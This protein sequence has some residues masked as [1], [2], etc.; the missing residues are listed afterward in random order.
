MDARHTALMSDAAKVRVVPFEGDDGFELTPELE[1]R[2]VTSEMDAR[3]H[4]HIEIKEEGR[5]HE[6][7]DRLEADV[8]VL[9]GRPL[10]PDPGMDVSMFLRA[11]SM[12][13]EM[14]RG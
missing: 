5:E 1:A 12:Q 10:Q 3:Q 14:P 9:H 2:M 13:R 4:G 8:E 7:C 11:G 6:L